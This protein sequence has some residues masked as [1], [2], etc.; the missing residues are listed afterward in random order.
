MS[1]VDPSE[2]RRF[3]Q[4]ARQRAADGN[5]DFSRSCFPEDPDHQGFS[6]VTF[7]G[8]ALFRDV[9]FEGDADFSRSTFEGT[10]V[11]RGRRRRCLGQPQYHALPRFYTEAEEEGAA[12]V[13]SLMCRQRPTL[14]VHGW[15]PP[16]VTVPGAQELR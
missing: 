7:H 6:G 16:D 4:Q 15:G 11:G 10:V 13:V 5:A 8:D 2:A 9:V 1:T 14:E 3:W 12:A